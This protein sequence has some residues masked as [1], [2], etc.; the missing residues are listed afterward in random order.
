MS[1][2]VNDI[3]LNVATRIHFDKIGTFFFIALA[4]AVSLTLASIANAANITAFGDSITVGQGSDSGGYPPKLASLLSNN[5]KPSIVVNQGIGAEQTPQGLSRFDSVLAS[6]SANIVLIM[7]GTNDASSGI[8]AET[9]RFNLEAMIN[10]CKAAGVTPVL[11][12]LTPSARNGSETLIPGSWNPM[13]QALAASA[14]AKLADQYA[15]VLPVWGSVS[16]DGL[17]PN[18]AGYQIIAET[19]YSAIAS[20]IS[21]SG[22]VSS[23]SSG[24]GGGGGCFIATAAFGSPVE[25]H[26]ML[27]K[28]LRDKFLLTN[29]A[30]RWFVAEYYRRSPPVANFISHHQGVKSVVRTSLYPLLALS[31]VLLRLSV[32]MQLALAALI[33]S[34]L[35]LGLLLIRKRRNE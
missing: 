24:S 8:S 7:E 3:G 12:T 16:A 17:H 27:L 14:G 11:A 22:A 33:T 26:V 18:D 32:P 2:K 25:K 9:T 20:M 35:T 34:G 5:G 21:S 28:E 31:F 15:A 10:K 19:W 13:I 6:F 29:A 1:F 4:W 30:G 23:A